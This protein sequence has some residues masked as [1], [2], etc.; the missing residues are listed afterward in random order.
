METV[1]QAARVAGLFIL[2]LFGA[3]VVPA[4]L[5]GS[6]WRL[7]PV[8]SVAAV[9]VKEWCLSLPCS[10]F[11]GLMM[12]RFWRS[13]TSKWVWILPALWFGS[14]AIPYAARP[15]TH[16]VFSKNSGFW[17]HFS[18]AACATEI[19]NCRDFYAFTVPLI[20]ALSY[21]GAALLASCVLRPP[22]RAEVNSDTTTPGN[23]EPNHA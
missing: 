6:V 3:V 19:S 16:S 5:E 12:Y 9:V 20:R 14:E 1:S 23:E 18:G 7:I 10:A 4:I 8:H 11:M 17:F 15:D 13:G 22:L 21:S 2:D